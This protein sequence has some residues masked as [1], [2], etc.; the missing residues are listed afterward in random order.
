MPYAN[1]FWTNLGPIS[2]LLIF[3][4]SG[5]ALGLYWSNL[6]SNIF[7]APTGETGDIHYRL[8]QSSTLD[9]VK[10]FNANVFNIHFFNPVNWIVEKPTMRQLFLR[11]I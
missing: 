9:C 1:N 8:F 5:Q 7:F 6:L 11:V 3:S 4:I 10:A 2:Y